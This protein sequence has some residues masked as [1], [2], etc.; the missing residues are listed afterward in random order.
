[1]PALLRQYDLTRRPSAGRANPYAGGA[2]RGLACARTPIFQGEPGLFGLETHRVDRS[3][4]SDPG[5]TG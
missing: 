1:M 3:A 2:P 4:G 5:T